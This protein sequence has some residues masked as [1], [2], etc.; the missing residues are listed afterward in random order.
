MEQ[1]FTDEEKQQ[2]LEEGLVEV[3]PGIWGYVG[4]H[5]SRIVRT[6]KTWGLAAAIG[7]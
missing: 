3:E 4:E 1:D 7:L 6:M 2:F 5:K